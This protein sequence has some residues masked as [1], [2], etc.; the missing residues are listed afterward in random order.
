M[1]RDFILEIK[2]YNDNGKRFYDII[3]PA[4]V[5]YN[6]LGEVIGKISIAGDK[7]PEETDVYSK[8]NIKSSYKLQDKEQKWLKMQLENIIEHL[9]STK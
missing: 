5:T 7:L 8:I 6:S 2:A 4:V 9:C 3:L 1:K